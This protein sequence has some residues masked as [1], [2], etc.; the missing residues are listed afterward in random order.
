M[1]PA[2]C[3]TISLT[4]NYCHQTKTNDSEKP[5]DELYEP[6][7]KEIVA[8]YLCKASVINESM[9]VSEHTRGVIEMLTQL[10]VNK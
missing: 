5:N 9:R 2:D 10:D 8:E 3:T 7:D 4:S 6:E 1:N